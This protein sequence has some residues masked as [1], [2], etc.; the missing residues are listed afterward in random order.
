M[1]MIILGKEGIFFKEGRVLIVI[2]DLQFFLSVLT[3]REY[4]ENSCR[5]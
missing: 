2:K 4:D 1:L 5:I 3:Y